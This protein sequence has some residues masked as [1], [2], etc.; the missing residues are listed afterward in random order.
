ILRRT[1]RTEGPA[2]AAP[3][4]TSG[5]PVETISVPEASDRVFDEEPPF[6]ADEAPR[7]EADSRMEATAP[8]L[9]LVPPA[10]EPAS[11]A[12]T[13]PPAKAPVETVAAGSAPAAPAAA[14]EAP[15][16]RRQGDPASG[17]PATTDKVP[18]VPIPAGESRVTAA[19]APGDGGPLFQ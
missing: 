4:R 18:I 6:T 7:E 12:P 15:A 8:N 19:T 16:G 5:G 11:E 17:G 1:M 10:E 13:P 2:A 3:P 9:R 14:A